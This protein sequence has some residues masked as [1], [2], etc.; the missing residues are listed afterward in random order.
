MPWMSCCAY[1]AA[2]PARLTGL[3]FVQLTSVGYEHLRGLGLADRPFR[4]CNARGVFDTAIGE[5]S[6]GR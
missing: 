4:V 5:W 1:A 3:K 6:A 2:Q